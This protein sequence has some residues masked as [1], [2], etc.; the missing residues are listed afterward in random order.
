MIFERIQGGSFEGLNTH[1]GHYYKMGFNYMAREALRNSEWG[2]VIAASCVIID[3]FARNCYWGTITNDIDP[4][5]NAQY[6]MDALLFLESLES[7]SADFVLFDPPFSSNQAERY[8]AGHV[9]VYTD[10][11][12]VS[13]CFKEIVRILKPGGRVL[14][15][16]YNST[17]HHRSLKLLKGWLVNFGGSRNDVLMTLWKNEQTTLEDFA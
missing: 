7:R 8:E 15:L 10:P 2:S 13:N 16:G 11:R 3:P 5:T 14:K 17:R 9:N 1:E 4:N 6:H 12:Y